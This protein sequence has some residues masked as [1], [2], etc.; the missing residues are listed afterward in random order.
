MTTYR[1]LLSV[2]L[3][4]AAIGYAGHAI[5]A[6]KAEPAG[7]PSA[8]IAAPSTAK[9]PPLSLYGELP[10]FERAVISPSGERVVIVALL[11]EERR[12]I[13]LDKDHKLLRAESLGDVKVRGL[14]W[15][16]EDR[17][18]IEK[19]DT[20]PL[21]MGF[22]ADKAELTSMIILPLTKEKVFSVFQ[23]SSMIQG[24]IR[25]FHGVSERD[26]KYYGYFGGITLE[27]RDPGNLHFVS[28][29]PVLYEVDLK[30][31][32]ASKLAPRVDSQENWRSWLVGGDG[33][34][35]ATID[36]QSA[37][38]R[39]YIRNS[40][41]K[42]IVEGVNPLGGVRLVGFGA[43]AATLIYSVE[44][45]ADGQV[46][47]FELPLAGGEAK[48]VYA[49]QG[50]SGSFFDNRT[51]VMLGYEVAGDTPSY[52]FSDP[53]QQKA[54]NATLKAFPGRSVHLRSWN[55]AFDRLIVMTDGPGD[56]QSWW[57]VDIKAGTADILG[58][59]YPMTDKQV[60]PMRMVHYKAGDGMEIAAVLTLPPGREAKKLPVIILP[61]GGPAARDYPDFDWWAQALASRGYAVLQPNFRGSTGYGAAFERAG[62]GEWGRKMQTDIS[63]GLGWLVQEGI[64]DPGRA[65]IMG[66]S[67]GGYAAL[68]GVTLQKGLYRC[69][70]SVAGVS[71]VARMANTDIAQSGDN[72]MVRRSIRTE[73]GANRDLRVVSP[74]N[75]AAQVDAPVL[76][77]H[78][79]DDVVVLYDQSVNMANALRRAGKPVEFVTLPGEDH[80]LSRS[81]TRLAMLQA[82]VAFVEK[83]N[84]PD[85][86]P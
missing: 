79:K 84:P 60:G 3:A 76:L 64:A 52:V 86:A 24:G 73:W 34:V 1:N 54:V 72:Q 78:G 48:E 57:V 40:A 41:G 36:Y 8:V 32:R 19:S 26:G 75:F 16:G 33:T 45:E 35:K 63:D 44:D 15:A 85:P 9:T 51:R 37:G 50:I 81:A 56:P 18:L 28:G 13:V 14:S 23:G 42:R 74:V 17:V 39:W 82:A 31:G 71:D 25:G 11:Q 38:G 29:D 7:S 59:S 4:V 47:W 80:W 53:R 27:G 65:C 10:Q 83:H 77:I 68:A 58:T 61:H 69:A 21:G 67:Y 62:H 6:D 20:A 55:D 30:T 66:A 22:T 5:A 70:V 43:Q 49:E 12:L 2:A 46:R